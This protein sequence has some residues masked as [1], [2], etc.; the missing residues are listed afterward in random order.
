VTSLRDTWISLALPVAWLALH[1][2]V[3]R[4]LWR[5]L[6]EAE[7][8][9][10]LVLLLAASALLGARA[11]AAW[12]EGRIALS[13]VPR[14]NGPAAALVATCALAY[15]LDVARDVNVVSAALAILGA[16]GLAGL[17]LSPA[18]W[19]AAFPG[20]LL[21]V[22]ALPL[23]V[24]ASFYLGF[25]ARVATAQ[26][27]QHGLAAMGIPALSAQTLLVLESGIANVDAPCSGIRSAWTGLVFFLA[28]TCV[29]RARVGLRWVAAGA[30]YVALLF[31]A[32]AV[33]VAGVA[34]LSYVAGRPDLARIAHEPLGVAGF[35]LASGAA[36]L[37][38]RHVVPKQRPAGVGGFPNLA[39][40][41]APPSRRLAPAL[42]LC[43]AA[44]ACLR[45]PT[46]PPLP[47]PTAPL[48]LPADLSASPLP[49]SH[50]EQEL[51]ARHGGAVAAKASFAWRGLSGSLLVVHASSW[52][53]HHPPEQ[54][55]RGNGLDLE[56]D[57]PLAIPGGPLVRWLRDAVGAASAFYWFQ[58]PEGTTNDV[59]ERVLADVRGQEHRWALVTVVLDHP[60]PRLEPVQPLLVSIR[61]AVAAS[62][63]E[64][65][66]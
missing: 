20:A 22:A 56:S 32:N 28:A 18:A 14:T 39:A 19:R 17:Y 40:R 54:C 2:P 59:A 38:L 13:V 21:L 4:W 35:A 63:Q 52:R 3:V 50:A 11:V 55:L 8:A 66:P 49:L 25:P 44:L 16:Y 58:S 29:V 5:S 51:Y 12:R 60:P 61:D 64:G 62:F 34:L 9:T 26:F 37:A 46:S 33:R 27:A 42:A 48:A 65:T 6:P 47:P 53:A 43:L 1:A 10:S 45:A 15:M 23:G 7:Y 31:A 57:L 30:G 41:L 24:P 36:Y